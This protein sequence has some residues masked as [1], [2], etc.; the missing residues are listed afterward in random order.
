MQLVLIKLRAK[1]ER[2]GE[3]PL[4]RIT[5]AFWTHARSDDRLEHVYVSAD[6][7]GL[8]VAMYLAH[9]DPSAARAAAVTM[10]CRVLDCS[11]ALLSWRF[12]WR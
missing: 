10:C 3:A 11:P 6:G 8:G 9:T 4:Q 1:D 5:D 2:A 12:E 7:D